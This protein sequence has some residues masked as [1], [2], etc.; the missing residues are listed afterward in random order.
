[1]NFTL[2][3]I[4]LFCQAVGEKRQ[5]AN[6]IKLKQEH[7]EKWAKINEEYEEAHKYD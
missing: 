7:D 1:M 2:A 6:A 3:I 4:S 5:I